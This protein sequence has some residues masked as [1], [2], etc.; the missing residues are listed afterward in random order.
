MRHGRAGRMNEETGFTL[1][2]LVVVVLVIGILAAIA[3]PTFLS[4]TSK[5][6]DAAAKA[7]ARTAETAAETLAT[8]NNSSFATLSVSAL[9]SVEPTLRD[10][11][12]PTLVT[13]S[14]DPGNKGFTVTSLSPDGDTFTIHRASDG[15]ATRTCV[16]A[17]P[18]A[19][20]GCVGGEW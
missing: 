15:I 4:Q 7:Q 6:N 10:T 5:A 14:L 3:I 11:T 20:A 13:A 12:G 16:Q 9:Q 18:T 17:L 19:P 2:E 8:D 1:I